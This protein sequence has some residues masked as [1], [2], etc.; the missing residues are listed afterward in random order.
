MW[1]PELVAGLAMLDLR[2]VRS[3]FVAPRPGDPA[4]LNAGPG[5]LQPAATPFATTTHPRARCPARRAAAR[6][7]RPSRPIAQT[8]AAGAH[9]S[10]RSWLSAL[11]PLPAAGGRR[12]P[13]PPREPQSASRRTARAPCRTSPSPC[14]GRR[15]PCARSRGSSAC[16]ARRW[17]SFPPWYAAT[18]AWERCC[19]G[20]R[21]GGNA[22]P[23]PLSSCPPQGYLHE[24]HLSLI[25]AA[26]WA[27]VLGRGLR[28]SW[29]AAGCRAEDL[30]PAAGRQPAAWSAGS[31]QTWWSPPST[32]TPRRRAA[33]PPCA[34]PPPPP[35][36]AA[37]PA[38]RAWSSP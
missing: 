16:R 8:F 18:H 26:R 7:S 25:Q 21:L 33:G 27:G 31:A 38:H 20:G 29:R 36:A 17:R 6:A 35:L 22:A 9:A 10:A 19:R 14:S 34:L 32:S 37:R 30:P 2:I 13:H 3:P 4:C 1:G 15:R 11:R 12:L 5:P 24:G 28:S 23:Q